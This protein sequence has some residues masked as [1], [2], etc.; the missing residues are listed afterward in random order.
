MIASK[1]ARS[2]VSAQGRFLVDFGF[3][4]AHGAEAGL[5]AARAAYIAG[6]AGTATVLAAPQFGIPSTERWRIHSC[7][8]TTT[9]A[10]LSR[11]SSPPMAM[12]PLC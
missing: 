11:G 1:A 10:T 3:R 4:R 8:R 7:R 5:L 9:R 6:F 12:A 2:V